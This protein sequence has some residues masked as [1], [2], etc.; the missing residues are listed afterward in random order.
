MPTKV[1]HTVITQFQ[2]QGPDYVTDM[3]EVNDLASQGYTVEQMLAIGGGSQPAGFV[4]LLSRTVTA[5][6]EDAD[7]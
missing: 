2:V 1:Y 7:G 6:S 4:Y 5:K 3:T